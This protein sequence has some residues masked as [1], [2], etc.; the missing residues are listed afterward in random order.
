LAKILKNNEEATS[1]CGTPEYLAPE[2]LVAN[3]YDKAVDWWA[4]GTL[5]YEMLVGVTPFFNRNQ[6]VLLQKIQTAK[7][8]FPDRKRYKIDYSDDMQDLIRKL[9]EKDRT[10]RLGAG[11]EDYKD[12]LAH[13]FFADIDM[14][15]L[16]AQT[17]KPPYVP[18][19]KKDDYSKYFDVE[20]GQSLEQ[21]VMNEKSKTLI[22]Q[23]NAENLFADFD[24]PQNN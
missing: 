9:L 21:T 15:K 6:N 2:M 24:K 14:D 11:P 22:N 10:K 12:I 7:V 20:D 16:E 5:M 8:V 3:G 18:S 19:I 23:K 1:F 17:L 4:V 13:Q